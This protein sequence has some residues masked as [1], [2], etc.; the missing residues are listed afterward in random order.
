MGDAQVRIV[1]TKVR[2]AAGRDV[3]VRQT[4]PH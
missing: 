4:V 1:D 3:G 2:G